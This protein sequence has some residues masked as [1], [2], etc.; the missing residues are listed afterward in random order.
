[1]TLED[2]IVISNG[3]HSRPVSSN[4]YD[5]G[6]EPLKSIDSVKIFGSTYDKKETDIVYN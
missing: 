5:E 1:M 4:L 2:P 6:A 3:S